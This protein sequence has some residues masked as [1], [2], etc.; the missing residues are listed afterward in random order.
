MYIYIYIISVRSA[1]CTVA[2]TFLRANLFIKIINPKNKLTVNKLA[3]SIHIPLIMTKFL[4]ING[5]QM[6]KNHIAHLIPKAF[7]TNLLEPHAKLL[8]NYGPQ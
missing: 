7:K 8:N 4:K 3:Q 6:H 5:S 2:Q 1:T